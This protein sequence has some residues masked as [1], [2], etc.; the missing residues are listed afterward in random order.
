MDRRCVRSS[1]ACW[2]REAQ[3]ERPERPLSA[4]VAGG[5]GLE[6]E[7][8]SSSS[9]SLVERY[10]GVGIQGGDG[11]VTLAGL[12]VDAEMSAAEART[13]VGGAFPSSD[14]IIL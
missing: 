10:L 7:G 4:L 3:A 11:G 5:I 9:H 2:R 13:D 6:L 12:S 14:V 8:P 1:L